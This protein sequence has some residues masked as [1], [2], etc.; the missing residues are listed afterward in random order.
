MVVRVEKGQNLPV[1]F[2]HDT[3][4]EIPCFLTASRASSVMFY[5]AEGG[6]HVPL[7]KLA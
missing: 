4:L 6:V 7:K 3:L 1:M 2:R 5:A